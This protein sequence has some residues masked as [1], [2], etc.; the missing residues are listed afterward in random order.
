MNQNSIL[1]VKSRLQLGNACCHLVQNLLSFSVLSKNVNTKIYGTV[2]VP[3][4][5]YGCE[6]LTEEHRLRVFDSWV[7]RRI[8]GLK[9]GEV[10]EELYDL[11]SLPNIILVIKLRRVRWAGHVAHMRER[12]GAYRVLVGK[13]KGRR[14]L[15]RPRYR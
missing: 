10:I 9:W 14:P 6:T 4:V 2:I 15:E 7:L 8:C 12:S 11:Y 1:E 5:L 3:V 13:P